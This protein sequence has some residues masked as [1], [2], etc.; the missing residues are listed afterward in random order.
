MA[1]DDSHTGFLVAIAISSI[2]AALG[3]PLLELFR[4]N[5]YIS[6]W[7]SVALSI[8][9]LVAMVVICIAKWREA[10]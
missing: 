6:T 7:V 10:R 1:F 4:A 2:G 5:G 3:L 8:L 9:P